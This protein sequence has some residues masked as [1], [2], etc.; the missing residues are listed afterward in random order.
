MRNAQRVWS[1]YSAS[2][3]FWLRALLIPRAVTLFRARQRNVYL[4]SPIVLDVL[5]PKNYPTADFQA[6]LDA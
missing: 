2:G 6:R 5:R 1:L 4:L 3:L